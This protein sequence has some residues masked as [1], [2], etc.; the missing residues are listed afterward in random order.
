MSNVLKHDRKLMI[1][2]LLVEGNSLRGITRAVGAHRSAVSRVLTEVGDS[3]RQFLDEQMRNLKLRH[4]QVDEAWTFVAKKQSR[5][6]TIE[7]EER[8]DIGDMYLWVAFDEDTKLVPTF[9]LGKRS[10]D[11][12]RRFM[13]DLAARLVSFPNPHASDDHAFQLGQIQPIT[14]ISTDGFAPYPEAV[15]L[16]FGRYVRYGQC[17]K[18]FRNAALPYTPSE[19]VGIKRKPIF[20]R[21]HPSE[22]GTSHVERNNATIRHFVKRFARLSYCFSKSLD[23]LAAACA[24]HFA[25][26]NYCW[27]PRTTRITPAMAAGITQTLWSVEDLYN[28]VSAKY[29]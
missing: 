21:L 5:L 18:D 16:A 27:R 25:Y 7:R 24:L 6:T 8:G 23:N 28:Y 4:I 2:R 17:I 13:V 20:G 9:I 1:V 10:A 14:Q 12:A 19:I 11:M 26:F 15:D 3:C 22:I 29:K